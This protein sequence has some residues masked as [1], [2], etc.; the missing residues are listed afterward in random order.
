MTRSF[1]INNNFQFNNSNS[2]S[3]NDILSSYQGR[4]TPGQISQIKTSFGFSTTNLPCE[5][6]CPP[7]TNNDQSNNSFETTFGSYQFRNDILSQINI[8][9]EVKN[10]DG[11]LAPR[12]SNFTIEWF[13]KFIPSR[14]NSIHT[15]FSIGSNDSFN[16]RIMAL[17]I[18]L[19]GSYLSTDI[20]NTYNVKFYFYDSNFGPQSVF[21]GSFSPSNTYFTTELLKKWNHMALVGVNNTT[22]NFST[23]QFFV[24]GFLFSPI[25]IQNLS[26]IYT[27]PDFG[28]IQ[29]PQNYSILIPNSQAY[30]H[31]TIGNQNGQLIGS[32][33]II[34]PTGFE[35]NGFI[36]NFRW[37][38]D[39]NVSPSS[40]SS[41]S[42][43]I[44]KNYF[45]IPS[46]PLLPIMIPGS[47]SQ[48]KSLTKFLIDG[49]N[50][51]NAIYDISPYARKIFKNNNKIDVK[52]SSESI[53]I[54]EEEYELQHG[55]FY[56]NKFY[57]TNSSYLNGINGNI[58][59][60]PMYIDISNSSALQINRRPFTLEWWQNIDLYNING[61][62]RPQPQQIN[63][64][65]YSNQFDLNASIAPAFIVNFLN[66]TSNNG[67]ALGVTINPGLPS[68]NQ[69]YFGSFGNS[70]RNAPKLYDIS[71]LNNKWTHIAFQ[72]DGSGNI[73][74]YFNGAPFGS[75]QAINYNF[76]NSNINSTMRIGDWAYN[77]ATPPQ[78]S[79]QTFSGYMTGLKLNINSM[80]YNSQFAPP[81]LPLIKDISSVLI[82]NNY[83]EDLTAQNVYKDS[84]NYNLTVQNP[85]T[86]I[87]IS[88]FIPTITRAKAPTNLQILFVNS[89]I[90]VFFTP[91]DRG[92]SVI[93]NYNFSTD[94]GTTFKSF[95]PPQFRD[96]VLITKESSSSNDISSTKT[97]RIM[98]GAITQFGNGLNNAPVDVS[99]VK[100]RFTTFFTS[101]T[102]SWTA[103][104]DVSNVDYLI[105]GGGGGSA[106]GDQYRAGGGGGGGQVKIG[107]VSVVPGTTY[108][109]I[110]GAGGAGS[111]PDVR[112]DGISGE[113][114][115]FISIVALGGGGGFGPPRFNSTN[116]NGGGG[117]KST[118]LKAAEGGS[119]GVPTGS[120]IG[121]AGGGG[122]SFANGQ[123]RFGYIGGYGGDGITNKITGQPLEY[124]R[125]GYGAD[126]GAEN[127][128]LDENFLG[129]GAGG[130]ASLLP[131]RGGRGGDGCV[132]LKH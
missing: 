68:Q 13:S 86:N 36:T 60:T 124:G 19:S 6:L 129:Y 117:S 78:Q 89:Q 119:S 81:L 55:S 120:G 103:P 72:G 42:V 88:P 56:F 10:T 126:F 111:E 114:T 23:F 41:S 84:S 77:I 26:S 5:S 66:D 93:T 40:S 87:T 15:I 22:T 4:L 99:A 30:P 94:G 51:Y 46:T 3:Q 101:G 91:G 76:I 118:E 95:S 130:G 121:G 104:S 109:V 98:L 43:N 62:A 33:P 54:E 50:S 97:Y 116:I 108:T 32:P 37:T 48:L 21:F 127:G 18:E 9:S 20:S 7:P 122:G 128:P 92:G 38:T 2:D 8:Q 113:N 70:I 25:I 24:N 45:R 67:V 107:R 102:Y 105:V 1:N 44:Y 112:P 131:F 16:G 11:N 74:M 73:N 57:R 12:N 64:F 79:W 83:L 85:N 69:I 52:L 31:L 106:T 27:N 75:S 90:F 14:E 47:N 29:G 123:D 35:F 125:G 82:I 17:A 34:N 49:N 63:I 28:F 59:L 100:Q 132:I 39:L 58:P 65:S 110:V 80:S 115:S 96:S 71:D 53:T 61:G